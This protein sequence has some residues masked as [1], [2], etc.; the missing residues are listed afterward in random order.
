MGWLRHY[1]THANGIP[2]HD[3]FG[4][5]FAAQDAKAFAAAFR[6]GVS[7]L[8]PALDKD[9][10]VAL[11]GQIIQRSGQIDAT[12]LQLV[13][14]YTAGAGLVLEQRATAEKS[15]EK[16]AIPELLATLALESSIV[17]IEAMGTHPP[18]HD[19]PVKVVIQLE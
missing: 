8:L 18:G 13:M 4:R 16:T 1:L 11:D 17:T 6:R 5:V 12:P 10:V 2:S 15:N 19:W 3:C 7:G 9:E 14:A